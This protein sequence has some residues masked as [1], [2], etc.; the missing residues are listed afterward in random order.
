MFYYLQNILEISTFWE[1]VPR[2]LKRVDRTILRRLTADCTHTWLKMV[3]HSE[4]EIF[5]DIV[6][7]VTWCEPEDLVIIYATIC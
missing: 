6:N 7:N 1:L 2:K 3:L 4:A 5:L